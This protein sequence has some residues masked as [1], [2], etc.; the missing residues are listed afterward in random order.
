MPYGQG[1]YQRSVSKPVTIRGVTYSSIGEA[2]RT[3]DVS[4][5]NI[6]KALQ[7]NTLDF[8]GLRTSHNRKPVIVDGVWYPSLE[9]GSVGSGI[10]LKRLR[11]MLN[12]DDTRAEWAD[13]N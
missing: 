11:R 9:R 12:S 6:S 5:T 7:R 2:A 1:E 3:L 4:H 13:G 8:V 10:G